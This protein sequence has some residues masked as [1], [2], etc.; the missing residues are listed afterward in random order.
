MLVVSCPN[1]AFKEVKGLVT[2]EHTVV[3]NQHEHACQLCSTELISYNVHVL[4][5]ALSCE[6]MRAP[7]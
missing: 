5:T 1:P 6:N 4:M 2:L 3:L 7:S